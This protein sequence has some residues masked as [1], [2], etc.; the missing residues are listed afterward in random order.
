VKIND[1]IHQLPDFNGNPRMLIDKIEE[2]FSYLDFEA[3]Y[4]PNRFRRR[5]GCW[6]QELLKI[7]E[8]YLPGRDRGG[9]QK[10]V[11]ENFQVLFYKANSKNGGNRRGRSRRENSRK[12]YKEPELIIT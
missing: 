12:E 9:Y 6:E 5:C 8:N 2:V 7:S 11:R 3:W 1:L 10:L 4:H